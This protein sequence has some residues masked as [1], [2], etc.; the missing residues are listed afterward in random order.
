MLYNL[1]LV[2]LIISALSLYYYQYNII[3]TIIIVA[4]CNRVVWIEEMTA[5][6]LR[7]LV[8]RSKTVYMTLMLQVIW[9]ILMNFNAV[10]L[11]GVMNYVYS[12]GECILL[13]GRDDNNIT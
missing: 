11:G 7:Q 3:S 8:V 5:L 12:V 13:C 9:N 2:C 1:L 4:T 6:V 10:D